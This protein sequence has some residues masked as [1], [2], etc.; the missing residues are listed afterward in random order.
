MCA[1]F[2]VVSC[3]ARGVSGRRRRRAAH[4]SRRTRHS[5]QAYGTS[6][7]AAAKGLSPHAADG[8][9]Q[10]RREG[11]ARDVAHRSTRALRETRRHPIEQLAT[12]TDCVTAR[13]A[14]APALS[15]KRS[16]T[17]CPRCLTRTQDLAHVLECAADAAEELGSRSASAEKVNA[18]SQELISSLKVR[19]S[20]SQ[21]GFGPHRFDPGCADFC[22]RRDPP[23]TA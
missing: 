5:D 3:D 18:S 4:R 16:H 8:A 21:F 13:L 9:A 14:H 2:M 1:D 11:A 7:H 19:T 10:E 15:Y 17:P 6:P 22:P 23:D 20:S 12:H